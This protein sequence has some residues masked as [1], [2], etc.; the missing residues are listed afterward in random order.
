MKHDIRGAAHSTIIDWVEPDSSVLELGCGGGE[1]LSRLVTERS[2]KAQGIEIDDASIYLCVQKGLNVLQEQVDAALR[3]YSD[4]TFDFTIFDQSLQRVVRQPDV[5][6]EEALSVSRKTIVGFSN[7]AHYRAR[8][9]IFF[10]GRTPVTASLPY[11][12]HDTPNLHFLSVADF[13]G[14]C[15]SR[16]ILIE[17]AAFF[18]G[19]GP[20][21][22]WPNLMALT[23]FF[24]IS[25]G[26]PA[27]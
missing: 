6:L 13:R 3:D 15:D 27:G 2:V 16:N 19:S 20:T 7:F 24:Q 1:L 5:V 17:K 21:R 22:W 23:G 26:I 4:K 11:E 25:R 9:Q 12:W 10:K 18:T 14:Y 8:Y